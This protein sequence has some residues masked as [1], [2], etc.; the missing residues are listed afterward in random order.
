MEN[1]TELTLCEKIKKAMFEKY[2]SNEL[3]DDDIVS[4]LVLGFDLLNLQSV[5]E[6]ARVLGKSV[7][8]I[9]EFSKHKIKINQF[10]FVKNNY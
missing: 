9:R 8:G 3:C 4:V 7:R 6:N 2:S 10:T 1:P 5:S